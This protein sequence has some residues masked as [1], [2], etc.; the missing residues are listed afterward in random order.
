MEKIL[1][2]NCVYYY[3]KGKLYDECFI[4][5]PRIEAVEVL[6]HYFA[7]LDYHA[8]EEDALLRLI[9]ELKSA[10]LGAPCVDA[11]LFGMKKYGDSPSFIKTVL[12]ILTSS[13]RLMGTPQKA[14]DFWQGHL[15]IFKGYSSTALLTSLAAAYCD[16]GDYA[17][18]KKYADCAYALQ[19]GGQGYNNEL[20]WVYGRIKNE[21]NV[22]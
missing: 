10:E 21:S 22:M 14:I 19:G 1:F 13:Y 11:I 3:D 17:Q 6:K 12:P 7:D 8:Y 18:A 16:V 4:E 20:S 2:D 9:I 15:S 5:V